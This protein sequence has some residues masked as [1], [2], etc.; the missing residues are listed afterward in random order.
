MN[1]L[2]GILN[3]LIVL[4]IFKRSVG[5]ISKS[6]PNMKLSFFRILFCVFASLMALIPFEGVSQDYR[7]S[8]SP[9]YSLPLGHLAWSYS[10]GIGAR[11]EFASIRTKKTNVVSRGLSIGYTAFRPLADTLYYVVDDGGQGANGAG[12]GTAVFSKFKM[13]HLEAMTDWGIAI[14]KK[15]SLVPGIRFGIIYGQRDIDLSDSFG[16]AEGTSEVVGWGTLS[17]RGGV[18]YKLSEHFSTTAFVAYTAMIQL[19]DT[20]PGAMNYNDNTGMFYHFYSPGVSLNF[21]F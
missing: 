1:F 15:V 17:A 20:N 10:P 18:E 3:I 13:F 2:N 16:A 12:I 4:F 7:I 11:L 8:V 14:S 5:V 19:G 6:M 21:L 9:A